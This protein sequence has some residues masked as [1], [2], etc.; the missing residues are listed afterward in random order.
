MTIAMNVKKEEQDD[1]YVYHIKIP[2]K[3]VYKSANINDGNT[4]SGDSI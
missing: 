2:K 1:N 3:Q 4:Y